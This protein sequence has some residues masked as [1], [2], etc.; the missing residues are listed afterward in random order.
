MQEIVHTFCC[1]TPII[2]MQELWEYSKKQSEQVWKEIVPTSIEHEWE[3]EKL[4]IE[5]KLNQ[6]LWFDQIIGM[7][8]N[9]SNPWWYE[10]IVGDIRVV[11]GCKWKKWADLVNVHYI[12]MRILRM[13]SPCAHLTNKTKQTMRYVNNNGI[14]CTEQLNICSWT[15]CKNAQ[16]VISP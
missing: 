6:T 8:S 4:T 5:P 10:V 7:H 13:N 14:R 11:W 2:S 3:T 15:Q 16:I 12:W 9:Q 1:W